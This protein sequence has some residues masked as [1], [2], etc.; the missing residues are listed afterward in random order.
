MNVT[1]RPPFDPKVFL[2]LRKV[3]EGRATAEYDRNQVVFAQGDPPNAIFYL[4]N[5]RVKLTVVSHSG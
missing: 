5:G 1:A 2:G 4:Q 3:G